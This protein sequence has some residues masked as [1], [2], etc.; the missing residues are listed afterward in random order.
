VSAART[1]IVLLVLLAGVAPTAAAASSQVSQPTITPL[2]PGNG[3]VVEG[4]QGRTGVVTFRWQ[5]AWVQPTSGTVTVT[6][7]VGDR[8]EADPERHHDQPLMPGGERELL[9]TV[10]PNRF[11]ESGRQSGRSASRAPRR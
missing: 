7:R 10:R 4:S 5:T 11:Y 9:T 3:T 6:H 2:S 1:R 8:S